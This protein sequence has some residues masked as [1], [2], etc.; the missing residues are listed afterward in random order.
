MGISSQGD[1]KELKS[2]DNKIFEL[3]S[4]IRPHYY[5]IPL[6]E[7]S[8]KAKFLKN[9]NQNTSFVYQK[10]EYQP[11]K[12]EQEL[13]ELV[14][15]QG[16]FGQILQRKK[17]SLLTQN[18]ILANIGKGSLVKKYSSALYGRPNQPLVK[19]AE[20]ILTANSTKPD[21]KNCTSKQAKKSLE[22]SLKQIGLL[23]WKIKL[24]DQTVP[25]TFSTRK[26]V[27]ICR[28]FNYSRK[29]IKRLIVHEVQTHAIRAANG[30][31][32]DLKIFATGLAGY[33]TAEEGLAVY[34]E[35]LTKTLDPAL[36][37]D[38]A[39]RVIAVNCVC[40]GLDFKKTFSKLLSYNLPDELA[41]TY[42]LRGHRAGGIIKDH[43][44]LD[45]YFK[46]TKF[47]KKGGDLSLL[48]VGKIGLSDIPQIKKL[49]S[50]QKIKPPI[51]VPKFIKTKI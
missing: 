43:I 30:Y 14:I 45:G 20:K 41:W 11:K 47:A 49:L 39:G 42:A 35:Y 37:R 5:T 1:L 4:L 36:I 44:Y 15:P 50:K 18:K 17:Q 48:Y 3:N 13:K 10:L 16:P 29:E 21:K 40:Q 23:D 38:Y 8:E 26:E 28:R 34:S 2:V 22:K 46:V 6:N 27:S 33:Q 25:A 19:Q 9:K 31:N 24:T 32:Q 7:H 51:I 12:I